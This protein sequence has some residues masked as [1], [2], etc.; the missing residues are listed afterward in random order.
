[1][2]EQVMGDLVL[3]RYLRIGALLCSVCV[4][5]A[6]LLLMPQMLFT[7]DAINGSPLGIFLGF[8]AGLLM[9]VYVIGLGYISWRKVSFK[10]GDVAPDRWA[11]VG[12]GRSGL[13]GEPSDQ[14]GLL[15]EVGGNTSL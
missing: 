12:S 4:V 14:T 5:I 11:V 8:L 1:M 10:L 9:L 2:S 3:K 15:K 7:S 6:N 13:S